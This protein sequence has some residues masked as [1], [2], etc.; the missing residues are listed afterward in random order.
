M[1]KC[2]LFF[3]FLRVFLNSDGVESK[4]VAKGLLC[5]LVKTVSRLHVKIRSYEGSKS[6]E[7]E[8]LKMI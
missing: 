5:L 2:W 7:D 6:L 8:H 4:V 3:S 1:E